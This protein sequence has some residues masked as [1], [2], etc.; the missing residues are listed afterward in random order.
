MY[1]T[2]PQLLIEKV[3]TS[4]DAVLQYSKDS[5]GEFHPVTYREF[6]D[7]TLNFASG[8]FSL[9]VQVGDHVG[10]I[11]DNRQEW[12]VCSLGIMSCGCCDIPRG[13]E[14]TVKDLSYILS[15]AGCKICVVENASG[16]KKL[17]EAQD[18]LKE[19][20]TVIVINQHGIEN[21]EK[22]NFKLVTYEDV[23]AAGAEYRKSNEAAVIETIE[24][25]TSD[26]VATIIFTS[27]TTGVPKGVELTHNNFLCQIEGISD[28][29]GLKAGYKTLCVLPVWH[30]YEREMEYY[31]MAKEI[32]LC[33]GKPVPSMILADLKKLN[34]E[35]MACVPRI[36]DAIYKQMEKTVVGKSRVKKASFKTCSS[37]AKTYRML[38]DIIMGRNLMYKKPLFIL[39]ILNK[40]LYIPCFFLLPLKAWGEV[41]FF[42]KARSLM[43]N[44]FKVGMS[45]GGG[46]APK[47]DKFFN[48]IGMK[49]VEGYGL[50]ETAPIV[51]IRNHRKPVLG[52][53]GRAMPYQ[54]AKVVNRHGVDCAPGQLGVLYVRGPNIMKGYY[55]QPELTAEVLQEGWFNTGDLVVMSYKG[56]IMIKGRAKDTIVLRSGENVEPLPIE[57][58]L[59]ESPYIAQAVVLGQ[60]KNC[61][62]ALIIPKKDNLVAYAAEKGID[63]ENFSA[64]LKNDTVKDLIYSELERIV[65][66]KNGFKPFEK[67]GK[68]SFIEKPFTIGVELTAKG[69]VMRNKVE[70]IYKWQIAAMF[71]DS[72]LAQGLS[73]LSNLTENMKEFDLGSVASS[74]ASGLLEKI[75]GKGKKDK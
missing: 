2:I 57:N 58:K 41:R 9:G 74:V 32:S 30:V 7:L 70:E 71:S 73:G 22:S 63:T 25:G 14:A 20:E 24:K 15:F 69:T 59:V 8:L 75:P 60:D 48:S 64:V 66:P 34:P 56:D 67:V 28:V 10:L 47:L 1:S 42:A 6:Y 35:F 12:F 26:D 51:C 50:T 16:Y 19:L 49:V 38:H 18:E 62:G 43:G 39:K 61:L 37:A 72:V 65:T 44:H 13:S 4:P 40:A 46:L 52:T 31:Y 54:E 5:K 23:L 3:K 36:W 53:I 27:G 33:Y 45:G 55:K 29:F 21:A 17:V 68:F 11:A